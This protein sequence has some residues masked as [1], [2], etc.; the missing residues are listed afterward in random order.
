MPFDLEGRVARDTA[1]VTLRGELD[2]AAAPSLR[3]KI[4]EVAAAAELRRLVLLMQ[5]LSFM[6]SAG[7]RA[8]V[9]AKQKL[10]PSVD[11]VL[12]GARSSVVETIELT[13]FHQSVVM[14]DSFD[15][16]EPTRG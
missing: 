15:P 14:L 12:V 2:A 10:G 1:I 6:A 5:D 13:G 11:L 4:E 7:L 9:F 3:S 16:E 8:L